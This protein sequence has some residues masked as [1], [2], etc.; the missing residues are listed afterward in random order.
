MT[1]YLLG[2]LGR[3]LFVVWAVTSAAF[4]VNQVLPSDPARMAAG[5]QARPAGRK[6][7]AVAYS[8]ANLPPASGQRRVVQR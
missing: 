8:A 1:R 7:A 2:R 3:A 5:P 6:P 4:F